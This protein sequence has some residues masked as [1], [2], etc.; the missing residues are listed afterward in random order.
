MGEWSVRVNWRIWW[1]RCHRWGA[2]LVA[3][4]L[5]LVIGTGLLLQLK[6]E[7]TWVQPATTRGEGKVPTLAFDAI[8]DAVRSVPQAEV[9]TWED[10]DRLDVRP[11]RGIAKVVARNRW[12]VQVDL[13]T[14]TV[15]QV[16]YRRSDLI[17]TL[18]DGSWFHE[19]ARLWVFFPAALVVLGLWLTG[20]YLFFLP[21][22]VR[23]S[24]RGAPHGH[25]PARRR[26]APSP[27][28]GEPPRATLDVESGA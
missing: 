11:G 7:W 18:H 9:R 26:G 15:L 8:L 21:Y 4:P 12:E 5:L 3:L 23:W 2:L 19:R 27:A 10:V 25:T 24:R 13:K 17:E 1:R 22:A 6:K 16:A 14:A 28:I 20:M